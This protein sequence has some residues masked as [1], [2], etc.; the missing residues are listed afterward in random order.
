[1]RR[2][3]CQLKEYLQEIYNRYEIT[4][5]KGRFSDILKDLGITY[6][7]AHFSTL[8]SNNSSQKKLHSEMKSLEMPGSERL[9]NG[10]LNKLFFL[11]NL[12]SIPVRENA[13]MDG[14]RKVASF[15]ILCAS[16]TVPTSVYFLQ[17]LLMVI[18]HAKFTLVPLMLIH[19]TLLLSTSSSLFVT[20]IQV[21]TLLLL[22]ITLRFTGVMYVLS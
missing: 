16:R 7:K 3:D 9:H 5:S 6:K 13:R 8:W 11:T 14:D 4:V 10:A 1:M 20:R 17:W 18:L 22:W 15:H 2:P 12:A 21:Q 19:L